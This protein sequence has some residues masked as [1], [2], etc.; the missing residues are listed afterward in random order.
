MKWTAW[1]YRFM[2]SHYNMDPAGSLSCGLMTHHLWLWGQSAGSNRSH[3]ALVWWGL[4]RNLKPF[5][6]SP[7]IRNCIARYNCLPITGSIMS[8]LSHSCQSMKVQIMWLLRVRSA[9]AAVLALQRLDTSHHGW[10]VLNLWQQSPPSQDALP[11]C[12]VS[13]IL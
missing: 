9:E 5:T 12:W 3:A 7:H 10:E 8:I 2:L 13:N 4:T 1:H 6:H 11:A